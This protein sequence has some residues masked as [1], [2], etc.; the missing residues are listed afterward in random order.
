MR[1]DDPGSLM[2]N[3]LLDTNVILYLMFLISSIQA[4]SMLEHLKEDDYL[5]D[6]VLPVCL[7]TLAFM[8]TSILPTKNPLK[9][10]VSR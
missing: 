10:A 3:I 1:S 7:D 5:V 9:S 2:T 6:P 8:Y 4:G